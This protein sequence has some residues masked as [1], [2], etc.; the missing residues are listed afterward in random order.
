[1]EVDLSQIQGQIGYAIVDLNNGH[2]IKAN[3]ELD[4][5]EGKAQAKTLHHLLLVSI[6]ELTDH[7]KINLIYRIALNAFKMIP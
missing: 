4:G 7:K 2:V 3:G 5:E 1:M 6:S